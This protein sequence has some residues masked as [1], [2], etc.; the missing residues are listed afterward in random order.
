[1]YLH[2]CPDPA[3]AIRE[4]ARVLKLGGRLVITDMDAHT[5][6]WMRVEMADEWLG[7]DRGQIKAWLR[8]VD[9]VNVLVDCT[10]QCCASS[11]VD[12]GD[13]TKINVFVATGSKRVTGAGRGCRPATAQSR[14]E[15]RRPPAIAAR[16]ARPMSPSP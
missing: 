11:Q 13:A 3:A 16:R 1:M 7:F 12:P 10:S 2:H 5:H 9:L 4:M 15:P 8:E 14:A 6:A